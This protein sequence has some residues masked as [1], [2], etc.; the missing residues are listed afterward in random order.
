MSV[1]AVTPR[2][3]AEDVRQVECRAL[4]NRDDRREAN[5]FGVLGDHRGQPDGR[6]DSGADVRETTSVV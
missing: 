1:D 5:V 3:G 4:P 2:R 6:I